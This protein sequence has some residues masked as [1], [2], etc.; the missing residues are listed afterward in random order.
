[1]NYVNW[2][3]D[4]NE[5][6]LN[7]ALIFFVYVDSFRFVTWDGASLNIL[8]KMIKKEK[9]KILRIFNHKHPTIKVINMFMSI[10]FRQELEFFTL[11]MESRQTQCLG[12]K[13]IKM[14]RFGCCAISVPLFSLLLILA[15]R[16]GKWKLFSFVWDSF[17]S[18]I[19]TMFES[20]CLAI[21]LDISFSKITIIYII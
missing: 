4:L 1:M 13:P 9:Q 20:T 3:T 17:E 16:C 11:N 7:K 21:I 14:F 6:K 5:S 12:D 10:Y 8:G 15:F 2:I 18:F 19:N